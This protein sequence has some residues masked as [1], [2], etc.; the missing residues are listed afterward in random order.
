MLPCGSGKTVV[1]INIMSMLQTN[2]L[3]LTTNISAVH[4]WIAELLDKT[5]L[6]E[7]QIGEYTGENKTI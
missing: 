6:T 4:Q 3:I 5:E 1:G 2:T 7:D